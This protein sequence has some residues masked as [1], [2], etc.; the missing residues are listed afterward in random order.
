MDNSDV[1]DDGMT[2][3][4]RRARACGQVFPVTTDV[5]RNDAEGLARTRTT[6]YRYLTV[7]V[8]GN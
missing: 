2:S 7:D 3:S 6:W 5:G 4:G 1:T 8:G